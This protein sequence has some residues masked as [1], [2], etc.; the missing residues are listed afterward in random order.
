MHVVHGQAGEV[1][2]VGT[3]LKAPVDL[4]VAHSQPYDGTLAA[5]RNQGWF[6][7]RFPSPHLPE[8]RVHDWLNVYPGA[9]FRQCR[10]YLGSYRPA[11]AKSLDDLWREHGTRL[12]VALR[13][14]LPDFR[15]EIV[16]YV[17]DRFGGL[18]ASFVL[19]KG[20]LLGLLLVV[21]QHSSHFL[22]VPSR[23]EVALAHCCFF[24]LRLRNAASGFPASS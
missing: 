15:H 21:S 23:R 8:S 1:P 7:A 6:K 22:F 19:Y 11:E 24:F 5:I 14:Q 13:N 20:R 3:C 12:A 17:H 18:D 9:M 10:R 16:R 2:V 4:A